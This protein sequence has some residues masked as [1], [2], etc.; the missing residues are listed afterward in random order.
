ML[1]LKFRIHYVFLL[2]TSLL[3][4]GLIPSVANANSESP[5]LVIDTP[6]DFKH[7]SMGL[8]L[9]EEISK[10]SK[11]SK[12]TIL[13]TFQTT[14]NTGA[15]ALLS[16]SDTTVD[17]RNLT[18]ALKND[19]LYWEVRDSDT[20]SANYLSQ[21]DAEDARIVNDGREHTVAVTVDDKNTSIYLDGQKMFTTTG[22]A[23]FSALN[24]IN[25]FTLG[26]NYDVKGREWNFVG[27]INKFSLYANP[28]SGQDI[29]RLSVAPTVIAEFESGRTPLNEQVKKVVK[30][31]KYTIDIQAQ[32]PYLK[33]EL[34]FISLQRDHTSVQ[35]MY[36]KN[37]HLYVGQAGKRLTIPGRWGDLPVKH[38]T[39]VVDGDNI[40]LYAEGTL[41]NKASLDSK[42]LETINALEIRR[43]K[44][45][46]YE[47]ALN[48]AQ[49]QTITSYE[50][51]DE[52]ALFDKGYEN[53]NSYRI[54]SLLL[55]SKGTL[56]AGADQRVSNAYDSPN[57]INFVIRRSYDNG[58]TWQ[59]LQKIIDLPGVARDGASVIDSVMIEDK[60]TGRVI[61]IVDLFPG[62]VGQVNNDLGVGVRENGDLILSDDKGRQYYLT[63][64]GKVLDNQGNETSY[65]VDE[66]GEVYFDGIR[67]NN[68]YD[69]IKGKPRQSQGLYMLPTSYLVELHSD[70]QGTTWSKPRHINHMVKSPWMKFLGTGPGTGIQI[71]SGKYKGRLVVPVYFSNQ[72]GR[73]YSSAVIY[74]DDGGI[75]WNRGGSPNDGR[76]YN[77]QTITAQSATVPAS[78]LHEATV[79]Q[80]GIDE[81]T[82]YMRNLNPGQKIGVSYSKDGGTSWSEPVFDQHVP[83]IFSQP[84]AISFDNHENVLFANASA[85]LPYRGWGVIRL[86]ENNGKTWSHSRTFND[87]RY[88][89]QAMTR[90]PNGNIALL[91]EREWQG[92][93]YTELPMTWI[94]NYPAQY[95]N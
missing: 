68:Y 12:G 36:L 27:S 4:T 85:R 24:R 23:F 94:K 19:H 53:A 6:Q 1:R 48:T 56:I 65:R 63:T 88:V 33:E 10:V 22:T 72:G 20:V 35:E 21:A 76:K 41:L 57:D 75:T 8:K 15:G 60:N 92:I 49:V 77:G 93:Y 81:L 64:E 39:I 87:G 45:V 30:Q 91:W 16:A 13:L 9:N 11:L 52:T 43:A 5:V 84:N 83:E 29:K 26:A 58:K 7:N 67:K 42:S 70:D 66:Q 78:S 54:P 32:I 17:S 95:L 14:Q 82:L 59:G 61:V 50:K 80:S 55:T 38:I 2:V 18:L 89:Y 3:V 46:L 74:S 31:K 28:L 79:V 51:P 25:S 34:P 40:G 37:D 90:L 73:V 47:G 44:A 71:D 69:S 62:G 86:S